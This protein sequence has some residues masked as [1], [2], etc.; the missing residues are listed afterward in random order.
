MLAD[1]Q[2]LMGRMDWELNHQK[3]FGEHSNS[4]SAQAAAT[5]IFSTPGT[6]EISE[7]EKE[8]SSCLHAEDVEWRL[9]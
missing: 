3:L 5:V 9:K 4:T 7:V 2:Q 1:L 6:E 8:L